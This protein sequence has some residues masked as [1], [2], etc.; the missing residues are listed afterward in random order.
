MACILETNDPEWV[1]FLLSSEV[2]QDKFRYVVIPAVLMH[3]VLWFVVTPFQND[4]RNRL[5]DTKYTTDIRTDDWNC[6]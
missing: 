3:S 5:S 4:K 6:L 1:R 2:L